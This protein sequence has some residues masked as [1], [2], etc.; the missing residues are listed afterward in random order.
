MKNH[1]LW[2]KAVREGKEYWDE[3]VL[4]QKMKKAIRDGTYLTRYGKKPKP[5]IDFTD[6][7]LVIWGMKHEQATEKDAEEEGSGAGLPAESPAPAGADTPPEEGGRGQGKCDGA[8]ISAG[9][10]S[11]EADSDHQ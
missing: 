2:E 4:M 8:G 5:I 9:H 10:A 7:N 1:W 11:P 6:P 3:F